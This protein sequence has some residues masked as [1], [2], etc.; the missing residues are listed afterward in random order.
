MDPLDDP[1]AFLTLKPL[2]HFLSKFWYPFLILFIVNV[3]FFYGTGR[4]QG[5][6]GQHCGYWELGVLASGINGNNAEYV[7][8][9]FQMF[10]GWNL[11]EY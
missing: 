3:I 5:I 6:F 8:M 1:T 7:P 10:M 4:M 9:H 11:M 2:S